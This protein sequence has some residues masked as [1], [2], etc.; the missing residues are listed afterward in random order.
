MSAALIASKISLASDSRKGYDRPLHSQLARN[1][2][3]INTAWV[4]ERT[5]G[6]ILAASE[7]T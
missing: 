5:L 6:R 7:Q 3:Y 1:I 4:G 2:S